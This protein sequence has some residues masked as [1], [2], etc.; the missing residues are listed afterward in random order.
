MAVTRNVIQNVSIGG[1]SI[2]S[3]TPKTGAGE[4][5]HTVVL[6]GAK[7]GARTAVDWQIDFGAGHGFTAADVVDIYWA[8]GKRTGVVVDSLSGDGDKLVTF[9]DSG[10]GDALPANGTAVTAQTVTEINTDF[11]ADLAKIIVV[12]SSQRSNVDV[13]TE[14][15]SL[16]SKPELSVELVQNQ[17][18]IWIEGA[19]D[20]PLDGVTVGKMTVS[21]ASTSGALVKIGVLYD[22]AG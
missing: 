9:E 16:G 17:A 1:V 13:Y 5:S 2:N 11:E 6:A 10:Y 18:F 14:V 21:T 22:S 19:N 8:G 12:H 20:N 15:G 4:I 3:A 7:A